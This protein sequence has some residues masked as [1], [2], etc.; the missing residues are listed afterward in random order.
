MQHKRQ[1]DH[2]R[3]QRLRNGLL[4][5]L[6]LLLAAAAQAQPINPSGSGNSIGCTPTGT[7]LA[8]YVPTG[9]DGS[10]CSWQAIGGA[11][12]DANTIKNAWFLTDGGSAN[13][14]TGTTSTAFP[15]AYALGQAIIFKAAATNSSATT[16]NINSLGNK[17]LTKNGSTALAAGNKVSGTNYLAVYDGTQFQVIGYTLITADV[18][19]VSGNCSSAASPAVCATASAGSVVVAASAT[20]VVV[21]TTAVTA[22][23]QIFLTFDSSLGTKLGVTCNT[24]Q[25]ALF[26]VTARTAAT[27]F[28]ITASAPTTNSACFSFVIFN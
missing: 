26:G 23:S 9:I 21:N 12:V 14:V 25:P 10:T 6:F 7:P 19:V 22:N 8:G 2:M 17:N 24:T 18:P 16:I 20:T 28:T 3:V 1:R 15:G 11:S 27:S 13:A 4:A 5:V